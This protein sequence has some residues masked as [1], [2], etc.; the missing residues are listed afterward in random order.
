M[1]ILIGVIAFAMSL[2][3]SFSA[4]AKSVEEI[5]Q[6]IAKS[7][8]QKSIAMHGKPLYARLHHFHKYNHKAPKGGRIVFGIVEAPFN[9][10][11]PFI[12]GPKWAECLG[13]GGGYPTFDTLMARS[14][15]E[16]FSMYARLAE[17]IRIA[18]DRSWVIFYLDPRAKFHNGDPVTAHDVKWTV[19]TF[20]KC[21]TSLRRLVLT[22]IDKMIVSN[23]RELLIIFKPQDNGTYDQE[24]PLVIAGYPVLS[25]KSLAGKDFEKTGMEILLGS[26]PYKISKVSPGKSIELSRVKDYWGAGLPSLKGLYNADTI[27]VIWFQNEQVLF[28]SLKKGEVSFF[29]EKNAIRWSKGYSFAAVQN[30]ALIKEEIMHTSPVGMTGF[31]L[32]TS[33]PIFK[34]I[35]IRKAINLLY[36]FSQIVEP[37]KVPTESFFQNSEFSAGHIISDLEA[38]FINELPQKINAL[39]LSEFKKLKSMEYKDRIRQALALFGKAGFFLKAGKLINKNGEQLQFEVVVSSGEQEKIA[40]SF[41]LQLAKCGIKAIVKLIDQTQYAARINAHDFDT[42]LWTWFHSESP[43]IEQKSYWCSEYASIISRNYA[44]IRSKNIDFVCEKIVSSS[45]RDALVAW[46]RVL[47]RVLR[48][49]Y[50]IVPT[51]YDPM[52]RLVYKSNIGIIN[53]QHDKK[54]IMPYHHSLWVK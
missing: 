27:T 52:Y 47:D 40:V 53:Q 11:N 17:K 1:K 51:G 37:G 36:K 22:K 6:E 48:E 16:P 4:F 38:K 29:W 20:G 24:I 3:F 44:S 12:A 7:K 46:V 26:G 33:R 15:D 49:G 41:A 10:L 9:C 23:E 42:I 19:E 28:E 31:A 30:G 25:Q 43:G 45:S 2:L 13:V 34:N 50:Y 35:N 14:P 18:P 39:E 32:N 21:G 54:K 5:E 8:E